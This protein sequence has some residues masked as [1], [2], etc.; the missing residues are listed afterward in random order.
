MNKSKYIIRTNKHAIPRKTQIT[1]AN[2]PDFQDVILGAMVGISGKTISRQS[3]YT[4]SQVYYRVRKANFKF[5]DYRDGNWIAQAMLK[6]IRQ[7]RHIV[8]QIRQQIINNLQ[9]Y[10]DKK[11]NKTI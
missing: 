5:R 11:T 4:I 3:Q 2:D 8:L 6:K 9:K 7:D 10:D 1:N